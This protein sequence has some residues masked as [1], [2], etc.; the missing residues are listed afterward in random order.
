MT[1]DSAGR[2]WCWSDDA[3]DIVVK[4]QPAIAIYAGPAGIIIRRQGDWDEHDDDV[5]WFGVDQ[6]LA[7]AAAILEAASLDVAD[8]AEPAP[9]PAPC[10]TKPKD[11]TG[12]ERQRRRRARQKEEPTLDIDRD[13]NRDTVTETVTPRD[14]EAA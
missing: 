12:A 6:A 13:E 11:S 4:G 10:A 14:G 7:V 2:A 9:K 8:I 3:D 5:I 1:A